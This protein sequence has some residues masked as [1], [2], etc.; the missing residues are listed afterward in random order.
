MRGRPPI[1]CE[2]SAGIPEEEAGWETERAVV[3]VRR[4]LIKC[5][6]RALEYMKGGRIGD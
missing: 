5:E 4:S 6:G 2:D 3:S 1:K